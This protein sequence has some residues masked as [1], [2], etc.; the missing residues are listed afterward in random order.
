MF[1]TLYTITGCQPCNAVKT[2]LKDQNVDHE[3]LIVGDDVTKEEFVAVTNGARSVPQILVDGELISG[4][5]EL[6]EIV[7]THEEMDDMENYPASWEAS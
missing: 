7:A 1:V 5:D 3:I 4:F 6:K 2:Y